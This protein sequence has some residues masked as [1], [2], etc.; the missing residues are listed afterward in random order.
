MTGIYE[1]LNTENNKKYIGSSVDIESRMYE[2][3]RVLIK[4]KHHSLHL[5]RAWNLYGEGCFVFRVV[6]LVDDVSLLIQREQHHIDLCG[7][8]MLEYGYNILP[9]A[10]N[11]I[12]FKQTEEV[13][14][15]LRQMYLGTHRS[16][17]IKAKISKGLKGIKRSEETK[18]KMSK[19]KKGYHHTDEA[20]RKQSLSHTGKTLT[21]EHVAKIQ[22][23]RK[24]GNYTHSEETRKKMSIA[25][26]ATAK[27]KREERQNQGE[28]L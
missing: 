18:I 4:N 22:A 10:G 25:R 23:T 15:K 17:E 11:S 12:G 5:Q 27:R 1:I 8:S 14:D 21:K 13:K 19:A 26:I 3:K 20:K 7:S 9:I 6:E 24:A 28:V 16:E 2:H